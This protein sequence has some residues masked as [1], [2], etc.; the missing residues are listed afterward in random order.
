MIEKSKRKNGGINLRRYWI[1]FVPF[2]LF[3]ALMVKHPL[4]FG[5]SDLR[6]DAILYGI[7]S[8]VCMAI[9]VRI[10]RF[11]GKQS[12]RLIAVIL[13][14]AVFAGWQP[15]DIFVLR[16]STSSSVTGFGVQMRESIAWYN[17]RFR[18][19]SICGHSVAERLFGN[20]YI[21]LTLEIDRE[22]I[23]FA[24]GG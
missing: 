22:A 12:H 4:R 6:D 23:W 9:A 17:P 13:L 18:D 2:T 5:V 15:F 21:A 20:A 3:M 1:F 24:C 7:I 19:N 8:L 11:A 16:S 14:C 10:Y